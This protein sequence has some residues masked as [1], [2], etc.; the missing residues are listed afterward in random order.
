MSQL[1]LL[2]MRPKGQLLKWVGNKFRHA[3]EIAS[4]FP[5]DYDTFYEPF[6]G[7]GA[8]LA[9]MA[10]SDAI[11]SDTLAPL[12]EMWH[13]L[14]NDPEA[15]IEH[16]RRVITRY[17]DNPD[18]TYE[19]TLRRYNEDPNGRDLVI[20]SRTCYG[21][22][23]RFTKEGKMSTPI[24]AHSPISPEKF[25]ARAYRWRDR[26]QDTAFLNQSFTETMGA[27]G[28][29]D[30]I[31]CDP[32][33]LDSQSILYGSQDFSFEKLLEMITQC[34]ERGAKIA[35]SIDGRKKSG[36]KEIKLTLP[37]GVFEREMYVE[38]GSSMLKRFQNG[39]EVMIGEDVQER[40]LL[41]W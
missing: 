28:A 13:T 18:A 11:A 2:P 27:A 22:V 29:N 20:L 3:N 25:E 39:G 16:Y 12:I 34:K 38:G 36:K 1:T 30:L 35:L 9:T 40:L 14:Q 7:T 17:E 6:V 24:G 33:Y 26:I 19:E 15:L 21:G 31:Y 37:P 41:S 10:P 4:H 5:E 8:V 23:V 32:P